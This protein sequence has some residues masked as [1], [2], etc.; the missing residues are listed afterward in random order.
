M[1]KVGMLLWLTSVRRLVGGCQLL[2]MVDEPEYFYVVGLYMRPGWQGRR[3]GRALSLWPWPG[4]CATAG[5]E[6]MVLTVAPENRRA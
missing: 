1:A 5:A 6:G 3:L 4:R 2:R